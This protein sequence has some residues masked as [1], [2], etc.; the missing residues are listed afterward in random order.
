MNTWGDIYKSIGA[1][2]IINAIGSVTLLGGS[3]PIKEVKEA[4]D[5]ADSAYVPLM[6]LQE[7][8]GDH[9]A[10]LTNVPSAYVTSGAGS[11]LTLATAAFMAGDND[12]LIQQ[13]PDTQNIKNEILIQ[14]VQHYWYDRCIELAGAKLVEFGSDN[15]TIKSDLENAITD[16]TIAVHYYATE[17]N[18][19]PNALS[20]ENTIE[21]A[22]KYN[23]YVLV[24][25]AG[26]VFPLENLGKYVRMGADI[27][28]VAAKYIGA[29]Q[30]TGFALGTKDAIHKLSLQ[31]FVG[32]E[33]RRIRGIGRPQKVDRQEIIG[34]VTAVERW[35]KLNHEDRLIKTEIMTN[36]IIDVIKH[37]KTI[38][39]NIIDN[40]I[41]HQPF[42][43]TIRP[44]INADFTIEDLV[45]KL[46][47]GDPPVWTRKSLYGKEGDD[48]MDIHMF[49]L[50]DGE[51]NIVAA[52]IADA[53][54]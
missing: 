16:K 53:L 40:I 30:S 51:E 21:I 13:L 14:K 29:P 39:V 23:L 47:S 1:K 4:M 15:K 46:K 52:R 38:D 35:M 17:Q 42:G 2:P 11:A 43:L 37:I 12:K 7:K 36:K 28:C 26:Q 45:Q 54:K 34:C 49:G 27:Q 19:D 25:A 50:N 6:E 48:C 3:T 8:A 32:Y 24:D 20:L 44:N 22:K 18:I 41:G 31:S 33:G 9:I 10:K 5:Q